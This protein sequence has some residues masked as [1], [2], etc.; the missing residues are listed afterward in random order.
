M[1]PSIYH[2]RE[3]LCSGFRNFVQ[4]WGL[5]GGADEIL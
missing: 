2:R 4:L 3:R 5:N 1:W